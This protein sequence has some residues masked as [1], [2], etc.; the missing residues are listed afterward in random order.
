MQKVNNSKYE[1]PEG[2]EE[3]Q[4]GYICNMLDAIEESTYGELIF[5]IDTN[6]KNEWLLE[7]YE[8]AEDDD[9]SFNGLEMVDWYT[10]NS[11]NDVFNFLLERYV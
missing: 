9:D 1:L 7:I 8:N 3:Q 11:L 10:G 6:Y 2:S 4:F 5:K